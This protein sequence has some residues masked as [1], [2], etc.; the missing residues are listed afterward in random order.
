MPIDRT[1]VIVLD[2]CGIGE[3]PDSDAYGDAGSNTIVN[4]ARAVGGLN[5]PYLQRL[6]L[7]NITEIPGVPPAANPQGSYGVMQERSAGKDS[8]TGHWELMGLVL[9]KPF[10]VYPTGFGPHIIGPFESETGRTVIGNCPA[11]GTE[12]IQR[13]GDRHMA[14]GDLIVYTSADSVFQIAAHEDIVPVPELYHYCEIARR[15]LTG[16]DAVGRVIARPFVGSSGNYTRTPR[17]RDFSLKPLRP[18]LLDLLMDAGIETIGIGKIDDLFA[19]QGLTVKI[20]TESNEEGMDATLTA[21]S[22]Y[23]TG[24][25]FV[26]LVETDMIWG[27]RNDPH[28]FATAL[29]RFDDRLG[30]L[31]TALKTSDALFISADHGCDPTTPSTDHSRELVPLLSY[32]PNLRGG[33]DLG[34]RDTYAD[35]AATLAE[36]WSLSNPG[37]GS[38]FFQALAG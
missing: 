8:T 37:P 15:L 28:G 20:H 1:I 17:R 12:I 5:C 10:P 27:H 31:L 22:R 30:E 36:M 2:A 3:A 11:S 38:S 35:L 19:G 7:G 34:Q 25:I 18:T 14:T 24:M 21:L 26:N 4:T 29:E 23:P 16:D 33:I 32:G 9:D 6:G 13:L